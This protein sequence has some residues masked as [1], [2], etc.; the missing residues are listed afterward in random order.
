MKRVNK[1]RLFALLFL[2]VAGGCSEAVVEE[3]DIP[4]HALKEVDARFILNVLASRT[5]VTRSII[6]TPE[7]IIES[8]TLAVGTNDPVRTKA[9]APLSEMQESLIASLWVGQ[10]DATT[11]ERLFN[12]YI[13][14]MAG[15]TV[16]LKLKQS[17]NG[18]RSRVY[19]ISNAGDLG[20]I[21]NETALKE[22]TLAYISTPEG[23]PDNNLCK[24]MGYWEGEVTADGIREIKVEL[25]RLI[26]T[27]K[28]TYSTGGDFVFKP[29]SVVLKN[30]PTVSQVEAPTEQLTTGGIGYNTYTGTANQA[31]TTIYWYLPENM[32]GTVSGE[33]AVDSEKKKTGRGVTNATCIELTGTAIQGGVT[34]GDVTFRFY[35]GSD[36]NNY[37]IVR[38]FRYTMDVTL[39]GIDVSDERITVGEIPPIEV[40]PT[41]MPAKKGG[42]KEVQI[43]ARPGQPW[44]F[45]MPVWLSALLNGENIP[46]GATITHQGPAN[47]VFKAVE[48]NPRAESRSVSFNIDVNGADQE[49]TIVQAGSTLTKGSDISLDAE[50]GSEGA[51]SFTA[52][53]GLR[54]LASLSG[55]GWLDWSAFN[56]GFS[57]AEASDGAQSLIV[58]ATTSNPFARVRTGKIT[59]KAGES[60]GAADY[61]DLTQEINVTQTAST[62]SSSTK[63]VA[64][65][66]AGNLSSSFTVTPGLNWS[67]S[68]VDGS[69]ITLLTTSGGLTTNS[70]ENIIYS[71]AVNPYSSPRKEIIT[72]RAGDPSDG[73]TGEIS[74]TQEASCLMASITPSTALDAIVGAEG[75]YTMNGTKGL[76]YSFITGLPSW[77][78]VIN[79]TASIL[80]GI[81]T[82]SDQQ[83]TYKTVSIN[84]NVSEREAIVTVK[85]GN[86]QED[87]VIRQ[88]GSEF[89]TT[90]GEAKIA[91]TGGST[92]G[93]VTATDG[94]AWT[95]SPETHNGITVSP[96]FGSGSE[97]LTFTSLDNPGLE[98]TGIFTVL[99]TDANPV[100]SATVT[101]IQ[102]EGE[103][104]YV[105]DLQVCKTDETYDN[106]STA[107]NSCKNSTKEGMNDWRLPTL[108]ELETIYKNKNSLKFVSGFSEF[109]SFWYWSCT[110][111]G[112]G[113]YW[114]LNFDNGS[115]STGSVNTDKRHVRC[116]RSK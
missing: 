67:A 51:S 105:G 25:T 59:V 97:T 76:S 22:H 41:E 56:P 114:I 78:Q 19:F 69:W 107:T 2:L 101:V 90:D 68:V 87:V 115:S 53:E 103:R 111:T 104:A 80:G 39:I 108:N 16:N 44:E 24:M 12:Q 32:A 81:T 70:A 48:A 35:P 7:G 60:V 96:I 42:E 116:V 18:N 74:V 62:V 92:T 6:F 54:W 71:A 13:P 99:V 85:A 57:G 40:D 100:R 113:S 64:A 15:T 14:S 94:L 63:M 23:L 37:D 21:D 102:A 66:G 20:V 91:G 38:N 88:A 110:S 31:G 61:T 89:R 77:L 75:T 4:L 72:V 3:D 5:P 73:P 27:I 43:T 10:Y 106:W 52:T 79:G 34:Y 1:T 83:L 55:D 45:D 46:S 11:G 36:K 65:E 109:V 33:N 93:A 86:M 58:K 17:H 29:A 98:R 49:I 50:V 84:P 30:A 28:F 47:V 112:K 9:A 95:I 8:D 82:G 26:A